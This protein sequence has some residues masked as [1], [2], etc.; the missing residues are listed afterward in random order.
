MLYMFICLYVTCV[1]IDFIKFLYEHTQLYTDSVG[2]ILR[3]GAQWSGCMDGI[4]GIWQQWPTSR[5][6]PNWGCSLFGP[7]VLSKEPNIAQ[8]SSQVTKQSANVASKQASK[9]GSEQA[10]ELASKQATLSINPS[11]FCL[12]T[13]YPYHCWSY[14]YHWS[15]MVLRRPTIKDWD[16]FCYLPSWGPSSQWFPWPLWLAYGDLLQ[17]CRAIE[18]TNAWGCWRLWDFC[19]WNS[20]SSF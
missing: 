8:L 14:P 3:R 2:C 15:L 11:P 20:A 9:K 10:S 6:T 7:G 18:N 4:I 17:H 13:V 19:P 16:I 5:R 1:Y 12:L